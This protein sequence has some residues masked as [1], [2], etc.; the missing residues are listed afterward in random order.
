[1][2]EH[3]DPHLS[4]ET[5]SLEP[6]RVR[7]FLTFFKNYMS[8]S[9]LVVAAL[10]IPV[11]MLEFI[12][13]YAALTKLLSVYTSL[14]CFL[15]LGFVFYSRHSLAR[16]FFPILGKSDG[17][18]S[19]RGMT[20]MPLVFIF[21]CLV[22]VFAY[23]DLLRRSATK[24]TRESLERKW[25]IVFDEYSKALQARES[26]PPLKERAEIMQK[27]QNEVG[28][29]QTG[30]TMQEELKYATLENIPYGLALVA[31]YL[32]FFLAAEAAFVLMALREYLQDL[33][34]LSDIDLITSDKSVA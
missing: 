23:Q 12:P 33:L 15:L 29:L 1:M 19:S 11:T 10:P 14:F 3:K 17:P 31:L 18:R 9:T 5:Q 30:R 2:P 21:L 27:I 6:V 7:Q 26:E 13:T 24:Y 4:N 16:R 34:G 32:G 22:L 25:L 8:L 20:A 28:L